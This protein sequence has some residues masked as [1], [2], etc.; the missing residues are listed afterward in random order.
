L[1]GHGV[2][3]A[4]TVVLVGDPNPRRSDEPFGAVEMQTAVI[5]CTTE[6]GM[7][8]RKDPSSAVAP[9]AS[10]A[11]PA[12]TRTSANLIG[13][14]VTVPVNP[15]RPNSRSWYRNRPDAT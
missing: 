4:E 8:T 3:V 7:L 10:V 14:E 2:V 12:M 1:G 9:V 13:R 15:S 11:A 6:P 5:A